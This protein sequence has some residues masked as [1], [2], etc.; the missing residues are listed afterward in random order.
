MERLIRVH[1]GEFGH[2]VLLDNGLFN[3]TCD[4]VKYLLCQKKRRYR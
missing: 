2:L 3:K 4:K 1:G